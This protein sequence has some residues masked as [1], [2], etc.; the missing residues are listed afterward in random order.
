MAQRRLIDFPATDGTNP[1]RSQFIAR[2]GRRPAFL[3]SAAF[4]AKQ[5]FAHTPAMSPGG[6]ADFL[7]DPAIRPAFLGGAAFI[8]KQSFALTPAM[9][10]GG[11][12]DFLRDPAIR[13]AFL[14]SAAFIAKQSFAHTPAM[15]PRWERRF[16]ARSGR[17]A[18]HPYNG[19]TSRIIGMAV[20]S[21]TNDSGKPSFQ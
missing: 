13:P 11:S 21:T 19:Q 7:R 18:G 4:I 17:Q 6:S 16:S 1:C 3:G 20:T 5:S 9:S 15:S 10:P 12:A 14:G 8:A 2:S